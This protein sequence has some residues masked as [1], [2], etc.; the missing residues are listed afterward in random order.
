[1]KENTLPAGMTIGDVIE[2]LTDILDGDSAW[3]EIQYHTGLPE[4]RCREIESLYG[5][6]MS[7]NDH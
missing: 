1:M 3:H 5:R 2:A 7:H 4:D 6:L